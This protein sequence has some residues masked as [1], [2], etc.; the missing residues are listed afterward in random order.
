MNTKDEYIETLTSE[1]K[2]KSTS[3]SETIILTDWNL[4]TFILNLLI[5]E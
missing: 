3:P 4:L 1:L 2:E 5:T